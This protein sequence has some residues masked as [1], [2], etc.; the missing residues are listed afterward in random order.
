MTIKIEHEQKFSNQK[1]QWEHYLVVIRDKDGTLKDTVTIDK[2]NF[3]E[4][5][6]L[7]NEMDV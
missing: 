3:L 4:L 5:K 2:D 7:L 1:L 6:K